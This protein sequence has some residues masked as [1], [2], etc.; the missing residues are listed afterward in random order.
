ML[1]PGDFRQL[2]VPRFVD[3]NVGAAMPRKLKVFRTP[4]G[5]HDAY[6]A[7]PSQKAA[8]EAWGS[9]SNLFGLGMAELVTDGA[10]TKQPLETP[11]KVIKLAR[12]SA[13][14]HFAALPPSERAPRDR[15][16]PA[17]NGGNDQRGKGPAR[18]K[19]SPDLAKREPPTKPKPRP[20]RDKLDAA[21]ATL[22]KAEFERRDAIEEI[23]ARERELERE[24]YALEKR[25]NATIAKL[26][27]A[28]ARAEQQYEAA[29]DKW[30]RS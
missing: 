12:G 23:R 22:E 1:R 19:S 16:E 5:F 17:E 6:V 18:S 8:L 4:F 26:E 9:D 20:S 24:R 21:E 7:A 15:L 13:D 10:L 3:E 27:A 29:L 11:G 25:H 2:P 30:R 14:E 28:V